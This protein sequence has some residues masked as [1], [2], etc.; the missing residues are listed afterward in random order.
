MD[1]RNYDISTFQGALI[2][3]S[4]D[5]FFEI[6]L[7]KLAFLARAPHRCTD[8]AALLSYACNDVSHAPAWASRR[9]RTVPCYLRG[10]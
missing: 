7:N 2:F 4:F 9:D 3:R 6:L 1:I 5:I 8:S 10:Q